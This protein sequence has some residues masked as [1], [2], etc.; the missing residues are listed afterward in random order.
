MNQYNDFEFKDAQQNNEPDYYA[1]YVNEKTKEARSVFS[2]YHLSL[3]LFIVISYAVIIAAEIILVLFLGPNGFDRLINNAYAPLIFNVVAMYMIAFPIFVLLIKNMKTEKREKNKMGAGEFLSLLLIGEF[4]MFVG[5]IIGQFLNSII[6]IFIGNDI[7]NSIDELINNSPIW[8]IFL[9]TVIIAPIIEELMFRKFMIDRLSRYGDLLAVIVSSIGFGLFH[10][11]FYQ[12]FYAAM[13]GF[14]LGYIYTKTRNVKYSILMHMII[15][16]LGSVAVL[17]II[18]ALDKFTEMSI[19]LEEGGQIDYAAFIKSALAVMSYSIIQYSL[20]IAGAVVLIL[21]IRRRLFK[22][23]KKCEYSLPKER[24][25]GIVIL[26]VGVILF[27]VT[28]I[29]IFGLNILS[30]ALMK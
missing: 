23:E 15:N 8:L 10:G 19:I 27:L 20:Y 21:Y 4:L 9:V 7:T 30:E 1:L 3:F 11:N 17:P 14:I 5:N 25:L 22:F 18:N 28:S 12:F 2:R 16:F 13:L 29:A 26:N 24:R 6:G